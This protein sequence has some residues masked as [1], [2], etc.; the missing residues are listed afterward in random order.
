M[1]LFPPVI[2]NFLR[3][4]YLL[5]QFTLIFMPPFEEGGAYCVAHVGRYVG[6]SVSLNIVQLITQQRFAPEASNLVRR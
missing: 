5:P 6:M 4:H 1:M 3:K 2:H